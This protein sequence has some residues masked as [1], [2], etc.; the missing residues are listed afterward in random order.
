MADGDA[1]EAADGAVE[2]LEHL[3]S[4]G[5][6]PEA[7]IKCEV[8]N[9][10]KGHDFHSYHIGF[11][12][13]EDSSTVRVAVTSETLQMLQSGDWGVRAFFSNEVYRDFFW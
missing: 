11:I 7:P 9:K 4:L 13:D 3:I 1:A 10:L 8:I 6:L 12:T 5:D 2:E